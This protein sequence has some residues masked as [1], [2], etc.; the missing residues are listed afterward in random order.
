MYVFIDSVNNKCVH[1]NSMQAPSAVRW[2]LAYQYEY[3]GCAS[4]ST[5]KCLHY[6]LHPPSSNRQ[7]HAT[8]YNYIEILFT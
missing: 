4:C 1:L 3:W 8:L 6:S 7:K 5:S 2:Q